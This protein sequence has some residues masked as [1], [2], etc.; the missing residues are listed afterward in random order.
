M[1]YQVKWEEWSG[2]VW[3]VRISEPMSVQPA[4]D[5]HNRLTAQGGTRDVALCHGMPVQ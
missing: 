3:M 1:N 4:I 5:L 2:A